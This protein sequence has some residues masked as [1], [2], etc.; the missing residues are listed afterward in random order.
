MSKSMPILPQGSLCGTGIIRPS[1]ILRQKNK[2]L[3]NSKKGGISKIP[4]SL[5]FKRVRG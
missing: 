2:Q 4:P 1:A 5:A 3:F